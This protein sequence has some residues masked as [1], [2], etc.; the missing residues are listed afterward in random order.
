MHR[1]G[2]WYASGNTLRVSAFEQSAR[3]CT[4]HRLRSSFPLKLPFCNTRSVDHCGFSASAH[5][6]CAQEWLVVSLAR[7]SLALSLSL[8]LSLWRP[9]LIQFRPKILNHPGQYYSEMFARYGSLVQIWFSDGSSWCMTCCCACV[10]LA[11]I[12]HMF[13]SRK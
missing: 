10:L 5:S 4:V 13:Q 8:S 7:P 1:S 11:A 3:G 2:W 6:H 9:P 12:C